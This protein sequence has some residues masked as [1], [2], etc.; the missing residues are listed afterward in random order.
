MATRK[1]TQQSLS[2]EEKRDIMQQHGALFPCLPVSIANSV[3]D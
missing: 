1:L 2:K 3:C